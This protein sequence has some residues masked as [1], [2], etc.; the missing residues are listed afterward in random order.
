[1][2]RLFNKFKSMFSKKESEDEFDKE[3]R[4][5]TI[6]NYGTNKNAFNEV[7]KMFCDELEK[8][9]NIK[10]DSKEFIYEPPFKNQKI[11]KFTFPIPPNLTGE[12][13]L[14]FDVIKKNVQLKIKGINRYKDIHLIGVKK[15]FIEYSEIKNMFNIINND[16]QLRNFDG[17]LYLNLQLLFYT[18]I[19]DY[20]RFTDFAKKIDKHLNLAKVDY[21]DIKRRV[22]DA[23]EEVT[24]DM[25]K[26]ISKKT[27]LSKKQLQ[28]VISDMGKQGAVKLIYMRNYTWDIDDIKKK[29]AILEKFA[30]LM[31]FMQE[32]LNSEGSH[33][34][35]LIPIFELSSD[36]D[37]VS[38][39]GC[40]ATI[41]D[42][43][44]IDESVIRMQIPNRMKEL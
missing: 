21:V 37:F 7:V 13:G 4:S 26:S 10:I 18:A 24:E 25:H 15:L 43:T 17:P 1:M 29:P 38:A 22:I 11:I 36:T 19:F 30:H 27:E 28:N 12:Q 20:E 32:T 31:E 16:E 41:N 2:K 9:L 40:F 42:K 14:L 6:S 35:F 8:Q 33:K 44:G 3:S 34:D 5:I 23:V 39:Y